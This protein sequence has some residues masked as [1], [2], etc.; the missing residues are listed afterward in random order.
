M[1]QENVNSVQSIWSHCIY[2]YKQSHDTLSTYYFLGI[3]GGVVTALVIG[4]MLAGLG[5]DVYQHIK[6]CCDI[7]DVCTIKTEYNNVYKDIQKKSADVD[8]SYAEG[9]YI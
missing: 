2:R 7:S 1:I 3:I 9:R 6:G 5:F 8:R 4:A